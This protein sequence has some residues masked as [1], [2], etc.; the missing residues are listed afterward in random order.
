VRTAYSTINPIDAKRAAGYGRRVF[1]LLGATAEGV[2]LGNDFVGVIEQ[3]GSDVEHIKAG[4]QVVGVLL[5]SGC[6]AYRSQILAPAGL[7]RKRPLHIDPVSSVVLPYVFCTLMNCLDKAGVTPVG[8]KDSKVLVQGGATAL[9]Q[10]ATQ[11]LSSW[12]AQVSAI[13]GLNSRAV[14]ETNGAYIVFDR[15][16]SITRSPTPIYHLTMNF[17]QWEDELALIANL[18]PD[19][20][21]HV[22]AVHPL[23][24]NIDRYGWLNGLLRNCHAY[25]SMRR[26]I[27]LRTKKAS[28]L[29]GMYQPTEARI[30]A[31][32]KLMSDN[33]IS[34]NVGHVFQPE[35]AAAAFE[36]VKNGSS[37][38]AV[39]DFTKH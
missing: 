18:N 31:L 39:F 12:G 7:V 13:C 25:L 23:M 8:I 21:G 35:D 4:D 33:L 15:A 20:L 36:L 10:I 26:A 32:I 6:G 24:R 3:V 2:V 14:C 29:W 19:A 22:T 28:Y 11:L 16:H 37:T 1:N 30:D 34:L 9:G 17:G 38:R 5:A 27:R